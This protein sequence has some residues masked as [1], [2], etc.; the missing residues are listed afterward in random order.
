MVIVETKSALGRGIAD[1]VLRRNGHHPHRV[2]FQ[3][4]HRLAA[5]GIVPRFNKFLPAFRRLMPITP[6]PNLNT[7]FLQAA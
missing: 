7:S 2:L 6:A 4:L 5:I 3:I 1:T